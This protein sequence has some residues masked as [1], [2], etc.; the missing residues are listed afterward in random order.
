[1]NFH[2]TD[3]MAWQAQERGWELRLEARR[4]N[5]VTRSLKSAPVLDAPKPALLIRLKRLLP[6]FS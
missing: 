2:V 1:M 5:E 4:M 6:R 3:Q